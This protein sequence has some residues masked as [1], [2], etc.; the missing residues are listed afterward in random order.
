MSEGGDPFSNATRNSIYLTITIPLDV[1]IQEVYAATAGQDLVR[2]ASLKSAD[3][4]T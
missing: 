4:A 3:S 2:L 1:E